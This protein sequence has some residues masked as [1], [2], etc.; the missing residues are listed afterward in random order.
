M[1]LI[2]QFFFSSQSD[3]FPIRK[4]VISVL[5]EHLF[6]WQAKFRNAVTLFIFFINII[7]RCNCLV[8]FPLNFLFFLFYCKYVLLSKLIWKDTYCF[9][10]VGMSLYKGFIKLKAWGIVQQVVSGGRAMHF[11]RTFG[12]IPSPKRTNFYLYI[13]CVP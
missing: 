13:L 10:L 12:V 6:R 1:S 4:Q 5:Q 2:Y 8:V 7:F 9:E 3:I 11:Q